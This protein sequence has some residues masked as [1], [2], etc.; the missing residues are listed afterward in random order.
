MSKN[1]REAYADAVAA[2]LKAS[3]GACLDFIRSQLPDA[4]PPR[5]LRPED[6]DKIRLHPDGRIEV[7]PTHP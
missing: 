3:P 7:P 5:P 6:A 4:P 2:F 1:D